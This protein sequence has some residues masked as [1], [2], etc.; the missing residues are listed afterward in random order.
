MR[1][2]F[3]ILIGFMLGGLWTESVRGGP[4]ME[5][6]QAAY[7]PVW[8][9]SRDKK[10]SVAEYCSLVYGR[11]NQAIPGWV[12]VPAPKNPRFK[13]DP[14]DWDPIRRPRNSR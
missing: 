4:E 9:C 3:G 8:S 11:Q 2:V 7:I 1:Y 6:I 13:F 10:T 12:G 5:W 14:E